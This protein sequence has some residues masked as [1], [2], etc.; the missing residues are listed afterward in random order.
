MEKMTL[1]GDRWQMR[2]VGDQDVYGVNGQALPAAI[3]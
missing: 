3:R 2:I 1:N